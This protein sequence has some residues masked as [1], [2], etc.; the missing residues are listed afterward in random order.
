MS[1]DD[2]IK[3]FDSRTR[4]FGGNPV[5]P[6]DQLPFKIGYG[7]STG[8][9]GYK[10][11]QT[12]DGGKVWCKWKNFDW[13]RPYSNWSKEQII[14]MIKICDCDYQVESLFELLSAER[15]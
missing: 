6:F 10:G 2:K 11:L 12:A 1:Y 15:S 5:T 4:R 8:Y 14:S 9:P 7:S 3:Q 13:F